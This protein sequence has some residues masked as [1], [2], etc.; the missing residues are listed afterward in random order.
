LKQQ[1]SSCSGHEECATYHPSHAH[2]HCSIAWRRC[3]AFS[4]STANHSPLVSISARTRTTC[5]LT[6]TRR[7]SSVEA[8]RLAT[9]SSQNAVSHFSAVQHPQHRRKPHRQ[10]RFEWSASFARI[11]VR[12]R[13]GSTLRLVSVMP[14]TLHNT[15]HSVPKSKGSRAKRRTSRRIAVSVL[16]GLRQSAGRFT[17]R[18][19]CL[20]PYAAR[21]TPHNPLTPVWE[22]A[23]HRRATWTAHLARA[24]A[25]SGQTTRS[26]SSPVWTGRK[27]CVI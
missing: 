10:R 17:G 2:A 27:T 18:G 8:L 11:V 16:T 22:R 9:C 20:S 23:M 19:V 14:R 4:R 3:G 5:L 15:T 7:S 25:R 21:V 24:A 6:S 12:A 13:C 26:S 1:H